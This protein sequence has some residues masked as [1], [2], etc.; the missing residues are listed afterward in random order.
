[1]SVPSKEVSCPSLKLIVARHPTSSR[2]TGDLD[3]HVKSPDFI[4]PPPLPL[5]PPPSPSSSLLLLHF[6]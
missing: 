3:F 5:L 1:M 6:M 2:E 4:S